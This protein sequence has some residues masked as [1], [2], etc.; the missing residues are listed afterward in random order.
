MP[1]LPSEPQVTR[2]SDGQ[3]AIDYGAPGPY[4]TLPPNRVRGLVNALARAEWITSD[5]KPMRPAT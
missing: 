1:S 3:W 2:L 4:L 5:G